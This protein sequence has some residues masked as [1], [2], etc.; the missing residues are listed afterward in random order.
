MPYSTW[1]KGTDIS[2]SFQSRA[3]VCTV[4]H[5]SSQGFNLEECAAA[6]SLTVCWAVSL[7]QQQDSSPPITQKQTLHLP[8]L[9]HSPSLEMS[10]QWFWVIKTAICYQRLRGAASKKA[11][12]L[13]PTL[14]W[15]RQIFVA[16][17]FFFQAFL[18]AQFWAI[19][20]LLAGITLGL[21]FSPASLHTLFI[22]ALISPFWEQNHIPALC[23]HNQ[24]SS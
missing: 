24:S 12:C 14:I 8:P 4:I 22:L 18:V 20:F 10:V 16:L 19:F 2:T 1:H 13:S 11:C 5:P 23:T 15:T 21:C 6:P 7:P 17:G 9:W 3:C